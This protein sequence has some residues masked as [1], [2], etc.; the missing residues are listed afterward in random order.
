[1]SK[2]EPSNGKSVAA[3]AGGAAPIWETSNDAITGSD[4]KKER[5]RIGR[6]YAGGSFLANPLAMSLVS[7]DRARP[8]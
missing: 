2:T 5:A 8:S 4:A 3:A 6:P 7:W 1:M